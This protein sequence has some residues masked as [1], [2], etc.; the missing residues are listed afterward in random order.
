MARAIR[1]IFAG[2]PHHVTQRGNLRQ[3]VFFSD[4]DYLIYLSWLREYAGRHEVEVLAYCLMPNHVHLILVPAA[5]ASMQ[6]LLQQLHARYA[7]H[8]NRARDSVG[9]LWQG[10]YFS[11]A[12]D[13]PWRSIATRYVEL[14]PVC[15]G[16]VARAEDFPW[17]SARAHCGLG[18]DP[19]LS[20]QERWQRHL[21]EQSGWSAW[22]HAGLASHEVERIRTSA[23]RSAPCGSESFVESLEASAGKSLQVRPRGRPR[24]K[25]EKRCLTPFSERKKREKGV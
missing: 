3:R 23:T 21:A 16:M 19:V 25:G 14:N 12:L 18:S 22:L 8:V 24:K 1:H 2:T 17:S 13:E 5:A 9:H 6:L 15:A 7:R 20:R 4:A 10:R 11:S